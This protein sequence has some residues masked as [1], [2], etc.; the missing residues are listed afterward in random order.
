MHD[1]A[2]LA[3]YNPFFPSNLFFFFISY[4]PLNTLL[5]FS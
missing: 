4:T 3:H 2:S 1:S 5:I